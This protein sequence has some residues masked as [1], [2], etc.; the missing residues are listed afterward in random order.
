MPDISKCEN[1][2]CPIKETC[3]R[4]TSEPSEFRQAYSNFTF[5]EGKGCE[6]YWPGIKID[7]K[8]DVDRRNRR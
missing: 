5:V 8:D 7:K 2:D 1:T 3:Y 4:H 6:H